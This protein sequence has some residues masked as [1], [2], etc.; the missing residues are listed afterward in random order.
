MVTNSKIEW[1]GS[2]WNPITGCDKISLGCQHCYAERLANRLRLMG[3]KKYSNGFKLTLHPE[4]ID[5]PL[6]WKKP[7][8]VFVNSMSDLFHEK[9]PLSYIKEI[10]NVMQRGNIHIF[11]ILTKRSK[12][13]LKINNKLKWPDNIWMGVTVEN[14]KYVNRIDDLRSTI[15]VVKW[16]SLEPLLGPIS[17][18]NL[19]DIDWVVVGGESGPQARPIQKEWILEIQSQCLEQNVP[20]FFKQWGGINKKK[21]G[22]ILDGRV[23]SELPKS[24]ENHPS[25]LQFNL[26]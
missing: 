11:Q 16:L 22:R 15:A 25:F 14:S 23:W 19:T 13:L 7:R 4:L 17:N 18:L 5:E 21:T 10:F 8:I 20:F 3:V 24:F 12:R 26:F 9:V 1:T 6:K 2:T